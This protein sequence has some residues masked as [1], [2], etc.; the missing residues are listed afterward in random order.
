MVIPLKCPMSSTG[1]SYARVNSSVFSLALKAP[2]STSSSGVYS[3]L[4]PVSTDGR[5]VFSDRDN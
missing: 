5:A 2:W 1:R 3:Q 4:V